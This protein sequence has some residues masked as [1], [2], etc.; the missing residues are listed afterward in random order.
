MEITTILKSVQTNLAKHIVR[1]VTVHIVLAD[2]EVQVSVQI[3]DNVTS[4]FYT[5]NKSTKL[6]L[7]KYALCTHIMYLPKMSRRS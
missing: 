3:A 6:T 1:S 4:E 5:D 2:V 7:P